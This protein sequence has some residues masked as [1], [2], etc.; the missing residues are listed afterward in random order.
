MNLI[1]WIVTGVL[2]ALFLLSGAGK[3]FIPYQKIASF[4][5]AGWVN[6]FSPAFV[7]LLGAIE[8]VGAAG[9]ILPAV[10]DIAPVLVPTAAVGLSAIMVGAAGVTLRRREPGHALLNLVYLALTVFVAWGRFGPESFR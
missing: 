2:A 6:D 3:L 4:S 10:L 9:L 8:I 5:A 7:K 1:L